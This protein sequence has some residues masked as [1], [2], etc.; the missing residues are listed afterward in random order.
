MPDIPLLLLPLKGIKGAAGTKAAEEASAWA[1]AA[2]AARATEA[3]ARPPWL[4]RLD[5]GK[6][7]IE[8]RRPA[9]PYNEVAVRGPDGSL[10]SSLMSRFGRL[11]L[12][13]NRNLGVTATRLV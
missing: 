10:Y 4:E 9:Y 12:L 8:L 13:S 2:E 1:R 3:G 7:F 11:G 6:R 5:E